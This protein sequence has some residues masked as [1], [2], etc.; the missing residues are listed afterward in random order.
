MNTLRSDNPSNYDFDINKYI[1]FRCYSFG[2]G[3]SSKA[4]KLPDPSP[5]PIEVDVQNAQKDIQKR[6]AKGKGR[7]AST[8]AGFLETPPIVSDLALTDV[9]G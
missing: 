5:I 4:P 6:L 8:A 2:G 9:L 7:Q 1:P 3:G